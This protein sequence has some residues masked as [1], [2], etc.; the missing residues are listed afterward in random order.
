MN[1]YGSST[2]SDLGNGAVIL[3]NPDA[4]VSL[5]EIV[6]LRTPSTI[7]FD[8]LEGAANG[9]TPVLDYRISYDQASDDFVTL[10]SNLN[11]L[12]DTA[13]GLTYGLYYKFKIES[14]NSFGF[15]E[16]SDTI[17]ILCAAAPE[18]PDV[19]VSS[20][21]ENMVNFDWD[22]PVNNGKQITGY[23]IY[24]RQ[25]DDIY[26]KQLMYCDGSDLTVISETACT[27]PLSVFTALPYNLE[28][29]DSINIKLTA[30]NDYGESLVSEYGGGAVIQLVPDAPVLLEN[31]LSITLDDRI[32]LVW[33]DGLSNGGT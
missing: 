16:Y 12:T 27:I 20:V 29:G 24:F 3:T 9:G 6:E 26:S 18:Q 2:Q 17:T 31:V 5:A 7:S 21:F 13:T 8:W 22:T 19:P 4:P 33:Y 1:V 11:A 28:L 14:R 32:G 30:L 10:V 15:S 25:S 23:N